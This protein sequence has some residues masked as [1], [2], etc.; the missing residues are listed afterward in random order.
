MYLMQWVICIVEERGM[1]ILQL[2]AVSSA[3]VADR[4]AQQDSSCVH[5]MARCSKRC[6]VAVVASGSLCDT[7]QCRLLCKPLAS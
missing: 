7:V 5:H 3:A 2:Y 6:Q 1:L 4:V